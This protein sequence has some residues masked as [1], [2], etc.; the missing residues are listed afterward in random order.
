M[1]RSSLPLQESHASHGFSYP[2]PMQNGP[3]RVQRRRGVDGCLRL[4]CIAK[5][6]SCKPSSTLGA[7]LPDSPSRRSLKPL[8]DRPASRP[9]VSKRPRRCP[10]RSVSRCH[11]VG[12]GRGVAVLVGVVVLVSVGVLEGVY[13]RVGV[14]VSVGVS[15]GTSMAVGVSVAG[16]VL[17]EVGVGIYVGVLVTVS[18]GVGVGV[19]CGSSSVVGESVGAGV[20]IPVG[21][22][23]VLKGKPSGIA[24]GLG[25]DRRRY[26][27]LV[28]VSGHGATPPAA[29]TASIVATPTVATLPSPGSTNTCP[30]SMR[31]WL[32]MSFA[33]TSSSTVVSN[34]SASDRRVSPGCTV[35][36]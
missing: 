15:V 16:T 33:R 12:V 1:C 17:V 19:G 32:A 2:P 7:G 34:L 9:S 6:A 11:S 30:T 3:R 36:R 26:T 20:P 27:G 18:L 14:S 24:I 23:C 4:D 28:R 8:P 13:V 5:V 21:G 22:R 25:C 29:T 35:Y 10:A 31:L